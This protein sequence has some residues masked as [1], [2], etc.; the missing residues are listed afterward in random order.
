VENRAI[1]TKAEMAAARQFVRDNTGN[2]V[3][4]LVSVNGDVRAGRVTGWLRPFAV[5]TG[6]SFTV[7]R[8]WAMVARAIANGE[9]LIVQA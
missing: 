5:I 7:R 4:V 3:L 8:S 6:R 2:G 1:T 9:A